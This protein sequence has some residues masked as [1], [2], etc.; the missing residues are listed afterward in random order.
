MTLVFLNLLVFNVFCFQ[1]LIC[2]FFCFK[3][4]YFNCKALINCFLKGATQ[5]KFII[6][7]IIIIFLPLN[8]CSYTILSHHFCFDMVKRS[9]HHKKRR[10]DPENIC[11]HN[12]NLGKFSITPQITVAAV[13]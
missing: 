4:V 1:L 2:F 5:I 3:C 11:L 8:P 7:M 12:V 13:L 9:V 6:I 10:N